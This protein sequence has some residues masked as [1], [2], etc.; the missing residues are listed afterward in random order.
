MA[1]RNAAVRTMHLCHIVGTLYLKTYHILTLN[2][3]FYPIPLLHQFTFA[4]LMCLNAL[5]VFG[6]LT[7]PN[8][9]MPL[10]SRPSKSISLTE[11]PRAET[12]GK[13]AFR[14]LGSGLLIFNTGF[15]IWIADNLFCD[16][17]G[18]IREWASGSD[19]GLMELLTQGHAW[20]HLLTGL[21]ANWLIVGLTC[22]RITN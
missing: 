1:N 8:L 18:N 9:K 19:A 13:V 4:G 17:L 3:L 21:G 10:P 6:L 2:S 15:A 16:S 7:H 11:K 14:T 5:V 12:A 20:W 22:E